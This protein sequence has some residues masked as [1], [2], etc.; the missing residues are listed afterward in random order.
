[1][2]SWMYWPENQANT[3]L[4]GS[5]PH[6]ILDLHTWEEFEE[7]LKEL[8]EKSLDE[9]RPESLPFLYRG[10]ENACWS[11]TTTLERPPDGREMSFEHYYESIYR[12]K[13]EI[14]SCTEKKWDIPDPPEVGRWT[15]RA[16]PFA[17][18]TA[19]DFRDLG[20]SLE[21]H[22]ALAPSWVPLTF[23]RLDR[24]PYMAAFFAFRRPIKDVEKKVS[25]FVYREML[26]PVKY[27]KGYSS[28]QPEIYILPKQYFQT[29]Q[30]HFLQQG[31]Y[32][33]CVQ[34]KESEWRFVPHECAC[35]R[36]DPNIDVIWQFS[37][38]ATER[39][40]VL[41]LLDRS[42]INAFSL[43]QSEESLMETMAFR[44]LDCHRL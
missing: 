32:T 42:N 14:E 18:F 9:R 29:H 4:D 7:R 25:I 20:S 10:Q 44:E 22:G 11:V 1:M 21:L 39:L 30:R 19:K 31:E 34:N 12:A 27:R 6:T 13:S 41:K 17:R 26:N 37:L 23:P 35:G 36:G 16:E 40:K 43:F 8:Q 15:E 33:I 5:M 28:D 38:P 24:S 3:R 2:E